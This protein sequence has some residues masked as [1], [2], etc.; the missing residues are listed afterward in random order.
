[1]QRHRGG[2]IAGGLYQ[3]AAAQEFQCGLH[4]ALREAGGFREDA[5][6]CRHRFPFS[7]RGLTVKMEVNEI[8]SWLAIVADDV[9]HQDIEDVVVDWNCFTETGHQEVTSD[10]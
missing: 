9:A 4:G 10:M 5:Q 6:A 1:M 2:V 7:A 8:R 3:F